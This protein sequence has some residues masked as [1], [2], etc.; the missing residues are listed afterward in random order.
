MIYSIIISHLLPT[1]KPPPLLFLLLLRQRRASNILSHSGDFTGEG[2][3]GC[4]GIERVLGN[5]GG[6]A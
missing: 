3:G 5:V 2:V 6:Y 1:R 4:G